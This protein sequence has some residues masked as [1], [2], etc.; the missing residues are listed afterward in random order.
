MNFCTLPASYT[1]NCNN[2]K[3][4]RHVTRLLYIRLCR[5]LVLF[6]LISKFYSIYAYNEV[7]CLTSFVCLIC[8]STKHVENFKSLLLFCSVHC[9]DAPNILT[10][11]NSLLI[12]SQMQG[13]PRIHFTASSFF[14]KASLRYSFTYL[15]MS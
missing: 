11:K 6:L 4:S 10:S 8:L 7:N 15:S 3:Y 9:H 2:S 1:M 13:N 14:S 12:I 5:N